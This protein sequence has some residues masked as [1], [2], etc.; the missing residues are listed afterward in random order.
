V[1]LTL[2]LKKKPNP[3]LFIKG[4]TTKE[5]KTNKSLDTEQ[6]YSHG[7]QRGSMPRVTV[8]AGSMPRVTVLAGCR[9]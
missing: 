1:T 3:S 6:I 5:K 7:S 4:G 9:Q 8:L 2:T